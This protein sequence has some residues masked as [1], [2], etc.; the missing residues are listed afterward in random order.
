MLIETAK[1]FKHG[2]ILTE[3]HLQRIIDTVSEQFGKQF[4][5]LP[6]RLAF[7]VRLRNG[8][9]VSTYSLDRVLR[10]ENLGASQIVRLEIDWHA[11][12]ASDPT[13][14]SLEFK[15][16]D[17]ESEPGDTPIRLIVRGESADW[18]STT[19]SRL[20]QYLREIR[21]FTPNQLQE[22][23]LS[24][25]C[26]VLIL[27]LIF[28]T[29]LLGIIYPLATNMDK[30]VWCAEGVANAWDF[31]ATQ[32]VFSSAIAQGAGEEDPF[33]RISELVS[34]FLYDGPFWMGVCSILAVDLLLL[35]F[36]R[37]YPFYN[38]C[39][40]GHFR[41]FPQRQHARAFVFMVTAW[42]IVT[43]FIYSIV[44]NVRGRQT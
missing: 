29:V 43:S 9:S 39:W 19:A 44:A 30:I 36:V 15:N 12:R 33:P 2:F 17:V 22:K 32:E 14:V 38:F 27:P 13:V 31:G 20:E 28:L 4:E 1:T 23:N 41:T 25:L 42:T 3:S 18:V 5:D 10:E 26:S 40:G 21:R 34:G 37:Y 16:T 6:P 11:Q 7:S 24:R 35:F 8:V